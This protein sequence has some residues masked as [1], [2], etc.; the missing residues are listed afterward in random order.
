LEIHPEL[1]GG[2]EGGGE[3]FGHFGGD[4]AMASPFKPALCEWFTSPGITRARRLLSWYDTRLCEID[5]RPFVFSELQGS[6]TERA[7]AKRVPIRYRRD[8]FCISR[9]KKDR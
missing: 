1:G 4:S 8:P 5:S 9:Y 7:R 3:S 2:S 6:K